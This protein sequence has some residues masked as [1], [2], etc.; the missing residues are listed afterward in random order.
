MK[1]RR[2]KERS[3][4]QRPQE[5]NLYPSEHTI[6]SLWTS[7]VAKVVDRR[8]SKYTKM[9]SQHEKHSSRQQTYQ[10][11]DTSTRTVFTHNPELRMYG[12]CLDEHVDI[13]CARLFCLIHHF[14]LV[15][16]VLDRLIFH[17]TD[18][19]IVNAI[20]LHH[21]YRDKIASRQLATIIWDISIVVVPWVY[22]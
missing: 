8:V 11:F 21:F 18:D 10:S 13:L 12:D 22:E 9:R 19:L 1:E 7:S 16:E 5:M 2:K 3:E 15:D 14:D 17:V 20:N 4:L 6:H